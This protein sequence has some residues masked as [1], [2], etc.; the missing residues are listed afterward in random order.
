[1]PIY[2][3]SNLTKSKCRQKT[4]FF[5]VVVFFKFNFTNLDLSKGN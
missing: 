5:A 3:E 1:M 2:G 4:K